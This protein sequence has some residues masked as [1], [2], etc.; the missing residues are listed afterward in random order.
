[1]RYRA[2]SSRELRDQLIEQHLG[3]VK[4]VAGR[5]ALVVPSSVSLVDLEGYGALGLLDAVERYDPGRGVP[6]AAYATTRIRGAILDGLRAMDP[7]PASWRQQARLLERANVRLE[8][9]LGRAP[10]DA[11]LAAELGVDAAELVEWE[12]RAASLSLAYLDEARQGRGGDD[13]YGS[14]AE[15]LAEEDPRSDPLGAMV[16]RDRQLALEA[17]LSHLSEKERLVVTLIYY[18]DLTAREAA[19]VMGLSPSRISQLHT[20]AILRLRG[21][22]SR[23]RQEVL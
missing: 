3:L 17:A 12:R 23:R 7:A 14:A 6:F 2:N 10:E 4:H 15:A 19:E 22:L 21:R 20:R 5:M 1:M 9:R 18:E 8:E 11:E 13:D 16:R